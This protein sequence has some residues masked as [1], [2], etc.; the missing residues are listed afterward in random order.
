MRLHVIVDVAVAKDRLNEFKYCFAGSNCKFKDIQD[1]TVFNYNLEVEF[2]GDHE[3]GLNL[4]D[5][6][7]KNQHEY[8]LAYA[9]DGTKVI[10]L[11]D[12]FLTIA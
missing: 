11:I 12:K 6:I 4:M 8:L 9:K 10:P 5:L 1:N 2:D 7:D 3:I